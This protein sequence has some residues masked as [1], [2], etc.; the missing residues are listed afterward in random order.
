MK[1]IV[2]AI[3]GASGIIYGIRLV[4]ELLR[5]S[6]VYLV[7]TDNAKTVARYEGVQKK[8]IEL[9]KRVKTYSEHDLDCTIASS[10]FNQDAMV[11][12]PCSMK[13]LAGI[14]SGYSENLVLRVAE[15]TLRLK[16]PLILVIRETPLNTI[17]ILNMLKVSLAGAIVLPASPAFYNKPN[18][19]DDI[20]NFIVGKVL[21]I[22][23]IHHELYK[24]WQTY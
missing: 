2:V 8:L 16:R 19:I 11:I 23:G 4:E 18:S 14:A 5:T 21:D 10:S 1:K 22:L 15:N 17:H 12:A 13:T 6:E 9:V 3:T 7:V 20:I 24:K